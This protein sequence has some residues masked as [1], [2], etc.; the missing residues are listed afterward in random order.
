[1]SFA[2]WSERP[3]RPLIGCGASVGHRTVRGAS[4]AIAPYRY[5]LSSRRSRRRGE[6]ASFGNPLAKL[7]G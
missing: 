4:V 2:N 5:F 1:M 6:L 3:L 7:G